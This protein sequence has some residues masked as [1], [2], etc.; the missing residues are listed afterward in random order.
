LKQ[1]ERP[2]IDP[3]FEEVTEERI[4]PQRKAKEQVGSHG[5]DGC[6]PKRVGLI[7]QDIV[8]HFE[9]RLEAMDGKAMIVS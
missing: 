7:A 1:E 3:D 8:A 5:G 2:K 4:F 6:T 9:R